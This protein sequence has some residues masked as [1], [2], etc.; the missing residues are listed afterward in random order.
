MM[1]SGGI[2]VNKFVEICVV[3]VHEFAEIRLNLPAPIP[4]KEKKLT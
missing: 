2:E 4:D 1:I 3:E